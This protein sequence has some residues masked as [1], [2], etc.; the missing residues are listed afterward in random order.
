MKRKVRNLFGLMLLSVSVFANDFI[1]QNDVRDANTLVCKGGLTNGVTNERTEESQKLLVEVKNRAMELIL[2]SIQASYSHTEGQSRIYKSG[3][4]FTLK[5]GYSGKS[6][7][8]MLIQ[9]ESGDSGLFT[10]KAISN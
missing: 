8:L 5:L 7:Y 3:P 1:L 4:N 9:T 2:G 6:S 10:C